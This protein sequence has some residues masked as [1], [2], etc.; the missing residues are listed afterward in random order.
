M[1]VNQFF[2]KKGPFPLKDIIKA[3]GYK[4]NFSSKDEFFFAFILSIGILVNIKNEG[5]MILLCVL[6]VF[7]TLVFF[8]FGQVTL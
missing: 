4:G 3:I 5:I 1:P 8:P 2:V 7:V 6:I